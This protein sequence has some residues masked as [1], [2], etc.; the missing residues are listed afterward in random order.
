[1]PITQG[2]IRSWQEN[3]GIRLTP[4]EARTLRH[5][6]REYLS[7]LIAGEEPNRPMPAAEEPTPEEV[8][9]KARRTA[10]DMR[11]SIRRMAQ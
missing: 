6:S 9:E 7:E 5:L 1:M 4:W 2:E 3:T 10:D 8:A 11:A